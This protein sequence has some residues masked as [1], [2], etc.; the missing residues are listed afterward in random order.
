M[1]SIISL[2]RMKSALYFGRFGER[3][4]RLSTCCS[5]VNSRQ[6]SLMNY[7]K[8]SNW[9]SIHA[10]IVFLASRLNWPK[11]SS[12]LKRI[13]APSQRRAIWNSSI[14]SCSIYVE[15]HS[16]ITPC[17]LSRRQTIN[18]EKIPFPSPTVTLYG[19]PGLFLFDSPQQAIEKH[20][21]PYSSSTDAEH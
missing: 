6:H 21:M 1:P 15:R 2:T 11:Y 4:T 7:C 5:T 14:D 3:C 17:H 8:I 20:P 9:T 12:S 19:A 13:H 18:L 16:K 10:M